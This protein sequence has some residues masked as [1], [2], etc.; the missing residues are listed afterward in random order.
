MYSIIKYYIPTLYQLHNKSIHLEI[1]VFCQILR[2]TSRSPGI[3][4]LVV[5]TEEGSHGAPQL[6]LKHCSRILW[7]NASWQSVERKN[8]M[9]IRGGYYHASY[10]P[11]WDDVYG[12]LT[13]CMMSQCSNEQFLRD[14]F[15]HFGEQLVSCN[16][17]AQG[18]HHLLGYT[19]CFDLLD[20]GRCYFCGSLCW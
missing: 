17:C 2:M 18:Q 20:L 3:S 19:C 1:R 6:S 14:E 12:S 10:L 11:Y 7:C 8:P 9:Q 15:P 16:V 13:W 4:V 5:M